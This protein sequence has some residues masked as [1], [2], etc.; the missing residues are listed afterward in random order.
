MSTIPRSSWPCSPRWEIAEDAAQARAIAAGAN[1]V[2]GMQSKDGGFAAFD[3]DT[4]SKWLNQLPLADVEAVTDPSCPDLTGRVLE[5][6]GALGHRTEEIRWRAARSDGCRRNQSPE[7]SWW[8]R[9]GVNHIYGTFSALARIARDRCR[10]PRPWIRR[11]VEWLKSKQNDDGGWGE[12]CL[13]DKDPGWRGRGDEHR[14]AD[15]MGADR[16]PGGRR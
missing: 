16:D 5:M 11:A 10:P 12:S 2:N 4:D 3:T 13:S 8:G 9:W 7:G 14:I 6:L 1:W 15:R